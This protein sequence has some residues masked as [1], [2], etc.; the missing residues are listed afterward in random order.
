MNLM[1]SICCLFS[2]RC[3]SE[4]PEGRKPDRDASDTTPGDANTGA[5]KSPGP[6][7]RPKSPLRYV[8]EMEVRNEDI[9]ISAADK[10]DSEEI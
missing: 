5:Q 2:S 6:T 10:K 9:S 7:S 1:Q 4:A 3:A 8:M